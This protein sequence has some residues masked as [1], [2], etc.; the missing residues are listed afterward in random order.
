MQI[1]DSCGVWPFLHIKDLLMIF[2]TNRCYRSRIF[3]VEDLKY[4]L[5]QCGHCHNGCVLLV[6]V[7][8]N[9]V[10]A[11]LVET[12]HHSLKVQALICF[13][14][15]LHHRRQQKGSALRYCLYIPLYTTLTFFFL[16]RSLY[17]SEYTCC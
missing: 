11:A 1:L 17:S 3:H 15:E 2:L 16:L 7:T 13:P 8:L 10:L 5:V 14:L 4:V 9:G 12:L 6:A